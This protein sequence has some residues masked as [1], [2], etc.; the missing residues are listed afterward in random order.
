MSV[1]TISDFDEEYRAA[2]GADTDLVD[3]PAALAAPRTSA[4]STARELAAHTDSASEL[5]ELPAGPIKHAWYPTSP[6][7]SDCVD[8]PAPRV[9]VMVVWLR[10][11]RLAL[12]AICALGAGMVIVWMPRI[13][14]RVCLRRLSLEI[15]RAI[16]IRVVIEDYRPFGSTTRGLIVANHVSYLDI[17]AIAVV[18]PAR[19]VAKSDV[20][21]MPVVSA[22]ARRLGVI[23]IDRG[24][25]RT[26]PDVIDTARAGLEEDSAVA[27]F[28]E[29]TTWCG[30]AGGSFRPAFFQSAL[31]AGVPVLPIGVGFTA[32]GLTTAASAFIGDDSPLDTFRRVIVLRDLAVHVRLYEPQMATGDRRELAARCEA[33]IHGDAPQRS[34]LR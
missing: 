20:S 28:P 27:V 21:T 19:F 6:C 30:R 7:G 24:S 34:A 1:L 18:H 12:T 31:D 9:G 8:E 4:P 15:L 2:P 16:G 14:R 13:I 10:L 11:A 29:G 26:L 25:L 17:L 32:S 3:R 33:M 23:V 22:L 5:A